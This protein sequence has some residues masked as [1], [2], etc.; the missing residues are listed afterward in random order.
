MQKIKKITFYLPIFFALVAHAQEGDFT[1]LDQPLPI[2]AKVRIGELGNGFQYY[3]RYNQRPEDKVEF[4]LAVNAG[5]LLEDDD[6]RGLA[7]FTEHMAF[8]GSE[9]FEKNELLD[10]V[11]SVGVEFGAHVNAYTSFDETVYK[12]PIASDSPEILEQAF[13]ILRDWATGLS[14]SADEIERERGVVLEE[15]R[16]GQDAN[17]RMLDQWLPVLL[18]DS[19]YAQRLPIGTQA[20]IEGFAHDSLRR[21]YE[22]WYRPDIMALIIVGD[23][24][25]DEMEAAVKKH[26]SGIQNRDVIR[27]REAFPVP[28]HEE[29]EIA[30]VSD[31]EAAVVNIWNIRKLDPEPFNTL[32]DYRR[33]IVYLLFAGMLNERLSELS[34]LADPPFLFAGVSSGDAFVRNKHAFRGF[35]RA[36]ETDI[37]SAFRALLEEGKRVQDHGF[38]PGEYERY[39]RV[40]LQAYENAYKERDFSESAGY[41]DEYVR[42][43]LEGEAIPGIEFEFR[44]LQEVLP[45]ISLDEIQA[46]AEPWFSEQNRVIVITAPE[47]EDVEIPSKQD[48]QELIQVVVHS[49][50]AAYEDEQVASELLGSRPPSGSTASVTNIEE[51]NITELTLSNGV[52]VILKP[53][54]FKNDEIVLFAYSLGG[55]SLSSD[56]AFFSARYA[57]PVMN[58]SGIGSF[59]AIE[60]EKILAGK[61]VSLDVFINELTEGFEGSAS[62][63]DLEEMMQLLYLHFT[64]PRRDETAFLSVM[65]RETE[66]IRNILVDPQYYFQDQLTRVLDQNHLRSRGIPS[67]EDIESVEHATVLDIYTERFDNAGDFV[68]FFT[69]SFDIAT[70]ITLCEQ[71][72]GSLPTTD[73]SE[74]WRDIGIRA[75]DGGAEKILQKGT[76]AASRVFLYLTDEHP[77]DR[78]DA[79]LLDKLGKL[80]DIRLVETL[81]EEQSGVYSIYAASGLVRWPYSYS[82]GLISFPCA[83][84]NVDTLTQATIVEIQKLFA[85]SDDDDDIQKI[86]EQHRQ[87]VE[88]GLQDNSWWTN[89]LYSYHIHGIDFR[90]ILRYEERLATITA[91]NLSRVARDYLNTD[92]YIRIVL[93]PEGYE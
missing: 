76:E 59:S 25:V 40:L 92:E 15:W 72:L 34:Q 14:L 1:D 86:R 60:L 61:S 58:Q 54:E 89:V 42:H 68:F 22:D 30:I 90:E 64:E 57:A 91:E 67:L 16:S 29:T 31:P 85:I 44:F 5:S 45:T 87:Q 78:E 18:K 56:D 41:A 46:L 48:V 8:N 28:D 66:R 36:K 2:D 26:F 84:E 7:H 83:P 43:F 49:E 81:R 3:I 19:R 37:L 70:M 52:R 10:Y 77:Y 53:T 6:Q 33:K 74:Q 62:S 20:S 21:F 73:I 32:S 9:H 24:D 39:K 38:T 82:Y 4:R 35:V 55:H 23:I 80:L 47:K 75:P 93:Y 65:N 69:G 17:R 88:E 79:F 71:Y 27:N 13:L 50:L 51:L 11:Q 12:L 63:D